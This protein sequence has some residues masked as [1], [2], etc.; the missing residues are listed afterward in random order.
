M[1]RRPKKYFIN[2]IRSRFQTV[3]IDNKYLLNY[4][5]GAI[6]T[7]PTGN[8]SISF[9]KKIADVIKS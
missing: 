6:S 3:A 2:D 5:Y 1:S 7:L 9:R 4:E 8:V